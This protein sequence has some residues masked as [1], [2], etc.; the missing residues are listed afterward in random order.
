MED[1]FISRNENWASLLGK[2]G[3]V[4]VTWLMDVTCAC[5]TL[6]KESKLELSYMHYNNSDYSE[7]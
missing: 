4:E 5:Q 7:S 2:R 6:V 3:E 1:L